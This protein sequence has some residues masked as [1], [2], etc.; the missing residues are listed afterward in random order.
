VGGTAGRRGR[1]VTAILSVRRLSV[2]LGADAVL[3]VGALDI[4]TG[5]LAVVAGDAGSG[6]TVLAAALAGALEASGEVRLD[7]ARLSGAPSRR[8][9]A[10][11][12][13]SVRD[14]SRITGCTVEEA[15][16]LSAG[17]TLRRDAALERFPA[18]RQR[19][20]LPAQLLSGGEQQMLQIACA[21]CAGARALV[22]D[23]P[24]VGLAAEVAATVAALAREEAERG[25]AVLWLEQDLRAAPAPAAYRLVRGRVESA[26]ASAKA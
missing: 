18:L 9:R 12:A 16:A 11:L 3:D 19:R 25:C 17:G 7:G 8:R 10:G 14:G 21:W 26:A 20:R 15:L 23:S 4:A 22:L 13:A 6:K 5:E 24:T 1:D 2:V